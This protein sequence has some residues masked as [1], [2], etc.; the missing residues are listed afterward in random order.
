MSWKNYT[1]WLQKGYSAPRSKG[2]YQT[3]CRT[4]QETG[5]TAGQLDAPVMGCAA[6]FAQGR[7]LEEWHWR[8][9]VSTF[10]INQDP[11]LA[12]YQN[13]WKTKQ[14]QNLRVCV[15]VGERETLFARARGVGETGKGAKVTQRHKRSEFWWPNFIQTPLNMMRLNKLCSFAQNIDLRN[16]HNKTKKRPFK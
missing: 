6:Q 14:K 2:W 16:Y 15:L 7:L 5:N 8:N 9:L 12:F 11:G 13:N 3:S 1:F 10:R 4:E